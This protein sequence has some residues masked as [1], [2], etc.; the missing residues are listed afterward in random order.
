MSELRDFWRGREAIISAAQRWVGRDFEP[1]A[2]HGIN[3]DKSCT[4]G[5]PG[6][7]S[8]GKHP[9][10]TGWHSASFEWSVLERQLE[11]GPYNIGLRMGDHPMG[12]TLI[13]I[14]IDG[15]VGETSLCALASR[16][17][18]LPAT[19]TQRTGS[20]GW[21]M[22][23]EWAWEADDVRAIGCPSI[24][25]GK[26]APGIDVRGEGGQIVAAP[27]AHISG[28]PYSIANDASVALLPDGWYRLICETHAR[29]R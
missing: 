24:S 10:F 4:C 27:S 18:V 11:Q 8:A 25:A 3:P 16:C 20:G 6:C 17:G 28:A 26:L 1:I 22:I 9:L 13:A 15:L 21:H 12:R 5:K 29:I 19:L 7:R 14:D 2:L 23:F